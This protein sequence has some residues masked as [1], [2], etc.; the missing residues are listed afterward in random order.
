MVTQPIAGNNFLLAF[1]Y[2]LPIPPDKVRKILYIHSTRIKRSELALSR[3]MNLLPGGAFH[4]V[5]RADI[6]FPS[7]D[8]STAAL[9]NYSESFLPENFRIEGEEDQADFDL[10]FFGVS[11]SLSDS[12]GLVELKEEYDNIIQFSKKRGLEDRTYIIDKRFKVFPVK[13]FDMDSWARTWEVNGH[14]LYLPWTLLSQNEKDKLFELARSGPGQGAI[15]NIG[16]FLG[17]SSIILAS[18]SKQKGREKVHSFDVN[19]HSTSED[20]PEKNN[21]ADWIVFENKDSRQAAQDWAKRED[22]GIRLLLIDGDHRYKGCRQDIV[23]WTRYLIPGGILAVHD[24]CNVSED[25]DFS[26]VVRAVYETVLT[27][28]RFKDYRQTETLFIATRK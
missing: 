4:I 28:D 9:S 21:V 8:L 1:N 2:Q 27:R 7:L 17:G 11:L 10:V 13:Q 22:T 14:S 16:H 23:S 19:K 25:V 26:S 5:K 15:V 18:G 12:S 6:S 24:Y 20:L 3:L